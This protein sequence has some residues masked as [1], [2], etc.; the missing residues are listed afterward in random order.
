MGRAGRW[1]S[2]AWSYSIILSERVREEILETNRKSSRRHSWVASE[3]ILT[4]E[5]R[6]AQRRISEVNLC[7]LC[8]SAVSPC[9][10]LF[11]VDSLLAQRL[12]IQHMIGLAGGEGH[13]IVDHN[14]V[15][16][17][18]TLTRDVPQMRRACDIIHPDDW[19]IGS[20]H[21]FAVIHVH[22]RL[23]RPAR[24]ERLFQRAL[25]DQ[26]RAA[27]VDDQRRR[28]HARKIVA[29]NDAAGIFVER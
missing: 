3:R 28:L 27:G 9:F 29:S 10:A 23:A 21:R 12:G 24:F 14:G 22:R 7:V 11:S 26:P 8:A 1:M 2:R 5:T 16:F 6:S 15:V 19:I 25:C 18:V 20:E 4:A 13:E 17:L